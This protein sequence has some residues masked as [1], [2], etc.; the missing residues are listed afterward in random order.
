MHFV[1]R[2]LAVLA[3][4]IGAC[5]GSDSKEGRLLG[6]DPDPAEE[7]DRISKKM[8]V[9][10]VTSVNG[11]DVV[12]EW[13]IDQLTDAME[14]IC[15]VPCP[16]TAPCDFFTC[17]IRRAEH[18][19]GE[20]LLA[21]AKEEANTIEFIKP[22]VPPEQPDPTKK[23]RLLAQSVAT[24][25]SLSS[26]AVERLFMAA[27][28]SLD[29]LQ[30]FHQCYADR[31]THSGIIAG[32]GAEA[33]YAFRDAHQV[34]TRNVLAV[35]DAERSST[36]SRAL[37]GARAEAQ[38]L[39]S[40]AAAAHYLLGGEPG[41][42]GDQ[43]A[44]F[45]DVGPLTGPAQAALKVFRESGIA[46][47]SV[48][49]E[50]LPTEILLN[51][52]E[53]SCAAPFTTC[54]PEGS[55]R[56]RLYDRW[57]LTQPTGP[58]A[59]DVES[60]V[61]LRLTDFELARKYLAQELKAFS[62]SHI[63]LLPEDTTATYSRY[64]ATS[65][66]PQDVD[67]AFFSALALTDCGDA[68]CACGIGTCATH[69]VGGNG[70]TV[71]SHPLA[72]N[73]EGYRW[74]PAG[75]PSPLPGHG[76]SVAAKTD[77][78]FTLV[79]ELLTNTELQNVPEYV[80]KGVYPMLANI[81]ELA[82]ERPAR[83][84]HCTGGSEDDTFT[85]HGVEDFAAIISGEELLECTTRGTV[86]GVPCTDLGPYLG[87]FIGWVDS[88]ATP[89][90]GFESAFD[91]VFNPW[92][93][94]EVPSSGPERW[95][96]LIL[97]PGATGPGQWVALG[98]FV[99]YGHSSGARMCRDIP[100][101][102]DLQKQVKNA[103]MPD[104]EQCSASKVSCVDGTEFD[105]RLPLE[106]ELSS[107]GDD[108][109]SSWKHYLALAEQSANEAD[110]L[111]QEYVRASLESDRD[112]VDVELREQGQQE[113]AM[114]KVSELQELCGTAVDPI[115]LLNAIQKTAE[116]SQVVANNPDHWFHTLANYDLGPCGPPENPITTCVGGRKIANWLFFLASE[117]GVSE[118]LKQCVLSLD[119]TTRL[120]LGDR[121]L[122]V[123]PG[124]DGNLCSGAPP[125][126]I[127]PDLA[128]A[129]GTCPSGGTPVTQ[130]LQYFSTEKSLPAGVSSEACATLRE[131][132]KTP[133]TQALH[134][135]PR[136]K[137]IKNSKVFDPPNIR[138][139]TI[140][141]EARYGTHGAIL[142]DNNVAI[143]TGSPDLP[144]PSQP[145]WPCAPHPACNGQEGLFCD[146]W[147]CTTQQGRAPAV[148][149]MVE[150]VA[151]AQLM[152]LTHGDLAPR[153]KLPA[154][155]FNSADV[156][157]NTHQS[158]SLHS[159]ADTVRRH[160]LK[161]PNTTVPALGGWAYTTTSSNAETQLAFLVGAGLTP[162]EIT[163]PGG[164][165]FAIVD[166]P[167]GDY[168]IFEHNGVPTFF[169]HIPSNGLEDDTRRNFPRTYDP[170]RIFMDGLWW[171]KGSDNIHYPDSVTSAFA[172]ILRG[173]FDKASQFLNTYVPSDYRPQM[174]AGADVLV[175]PY[176]SDFYIK[177]IGTLL[178][179][180]E[181]L[182]EL[183]A[184][185]SAF[186]NPDCGSGITVD[187]PSD[188]TNVSRHI[189]CIGRK[190]ERK[191][192][193]T[194]FDEVP[195]EA[196]DALRTTT[197]V[198]THGNIAGT[199]GVQYSELRS[200]LLEIADA[201]PDVGREVSGLSHDINDLIIST[202]INEKE[203]EIANVQFWS[204][205][206][207]KI[208]D[209]ATSALGV[210]TLLSFGADTA[211]TC[212]NSIAQIGFASEINRL[213][214]E[215]GELKTQGAY[216]TFNERFATR[217]G[218]LEDLSIR[219][220]KAI[221]TV[222]RVLIEVRNTR[223]R[224]QRLVNE[225]MWLLSTEAK[226]QAKV[227][228]VLDVN[229]ETARIRYERAFKNAQL[230][231]FLAK[232]AIEQRL[233]VRLADMTEK[234]PLVDPPASWEGTICSRTGIDY[235]KTVAEAEDG[236]AL[237]N[238]FADGF[239][240]DYV[241][242]LKNVVESYRLEFNFHEGADTAV[243]SL[244]D[245]VNN[246]RVSCDTES[247]NLLFHSS[248]L[249]NFTNS[250]DVDRPGWFLDG[251]R[252]TTAGGQ[253]VN[254]PDCIAVTPDQETALDAV[255]LGEHGV[256]GF[257]V[258]FGSTTNCTAGEAT[259]AG[260]QTGAGLTQQIELPA[261]L[262][263]FSWYTPGDEDSRGAAAGFAKTLAGVNLKPADDP[264]TTPPHEKMHGFIEDPSLDWNRS[265]FLF[266]LTE[267]TTTV[268]LGF[269][270]Q[271]TAINGVQ[272]L[273][274]AAPM[275]ELVES[276]GP[277]V[278]RHPRAFS[279]TTDTRIVQAAICEDT[280]GE[281]FRLNE[282]SRE[283]VKLCPDGFASE[284]ASEDAV[285]QC[286]WET[287]FNVSQRSIESGSSFMHSG[288]ARG[289][290]NY[291][292]DSIGVNFVG[293]G[294]RNCEEEPLPSTCHGAG[295]VTYS[296]EHQGPYIVRNH[297]GQDFEAK[298]FPGNIE[299]ARGLGNERY[300]TNPLSSADGELI[301]EYLRHEFKG[302]PLDGN[303]SLRVWEEP[304]FNF[305][306]I[307]DVQVLLKYRYWT[308]FQ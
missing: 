229:K 267:D 220:T 257:A 114:G 250:R 201:G 157:L 58:G 52:T 239:I 109:E 243:V 23:Y 283:C 221:E 168:R 117:A 223:A 116:V 77:H 59:P 298:L 20:L 195:F 34:L 256:P 207:Q 30:P 189:E 28:K 191:A 90:P 127:C 71:S 40:R 204:T 156:D 254:M 120:H 160:A 142:L 72:G 235:D 228:Q 179:G 246:V 122:C 266:E 55:V 21:A 99:P 265:Y 103:L 307:Q 175:S 26:A 275:L 4:A 74:Y 100:L 139:S 247:K 123:W 81:N 181:L 178:D 94:P 244:R 35:S 31:G 163:G 217:V 301:A 154:Y 226:T 5:S 101:I 224:A 64:A 29:L 70:G 218:N 145:V 240:G 105:E 292:I 80:Q 126:N 215:I 287:S 161:R 172:F 186:F 206:A 44:G 150:A 27:Y 183:N 54:V 140:T 164:E 238:N 19:P 234:L 149:R 144:P 255:G 264:P 188:L 166:G 60:Y 3:L 45:C 132:R 208:T 295:Y 97:R 270:W 110:L 288:F 46:P 49:N 214:G 106:D 73:K 300:L 148:A 8:A 83:V 24:K 176:F 41:L 308:R 33:F 95:Y 182:C 236:S 212:A 47:A 152:R 32:A 118:Q 107:D 75:T 92:V 302:R 230:M 251:C 14:E 43:R 82:E 1:K 78:L 194:V 271:P 125:Q 158:L 199:L 170:L 51:G 272:N 284:C 237:L 231:S 15:N 209:C 249:D 261:G 88:P 37:S 190:I 184:K 277:N 25:V 13:T 180:A 211:L 147:D 151:A 89:A 167:I 138:K 131:I 69:T 205:V 22:A 111:G 177:G 297:F 202:K 136:I 269:Q 299:H 50:Q 96:V 102:P 143:S 162:M 129:N 65:L 66:P 203:A 87:N 174:P 242:N 112:A 63:A 262:Y 17:G 79:H 222:D 281:I 42:R 197:P 108:V 171:S 124:A 268:R 141:F 133:P 2:V 61:N 258:R 232:R 280:T 233:G 273:F 130:G 185:E 48:L 9:R 276:R 200:A 253:T 227:S 187:D 303:F 216:N 39:L 165:I 306:A 53:T 115:A 128:F 67:A 286:Y 84:V 289:N 113:K 225:A 68:Y 119:A 104:R 137:T 279:G 198:G 169:A 213:S 293:T 285:T 241:Q 135:D 62:R 18:C 252:T 192:S 305:H 153:M 274:V 173:Q 6:A 155:V 294:I 86:E 12:E 278:S 263:R 98:G 219:L 146:S 16:P 282:W 38:E 76:Y 248:R 260:W 259:C 304:G 11:K 290:F 134:D 56:Q 36:T 7:A 210:D 296:L 193:F 196:L 57:G 93:F 245:D 85:V 291:R 121:P 159:V 91:L 10:M